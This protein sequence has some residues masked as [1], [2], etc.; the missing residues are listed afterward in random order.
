[1][2]GSTSIQFQFLFFPTVTKSFRHR[3]T[4]WSSLHGSFYILIVS[5]VINIRFIA[6]YI[7]MQSY[8]SETILLSVFWLR[9]KNICINIV[10]C[11]SVIFNMLHKS[12]N[13]ALRDRWHAR[14]MSLFHLEK[15]TKKLINT[16][17]TNAKNNSLDMYLKIFY[18]FSLTI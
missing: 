2:S 11:L 8:K 1:M 15:K 5:V 6:D 3:N 10:S 17:L 16:L 12:N 7:E 13:R 4:V 9:H 18:N 14:K